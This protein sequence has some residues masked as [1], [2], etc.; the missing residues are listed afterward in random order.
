VIFR[1]AVWTAAVITVLGAGLTAFVYAHLDDDPLDVIALFIVA[2][3]TIFA[4]LVVL[5]AG[6]V[7]QALW[8]AL[9]GLSGKGEATPPA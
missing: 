8:K 1:V 9:R 2:G 6:G 5:L 4:V 7:G 3:G